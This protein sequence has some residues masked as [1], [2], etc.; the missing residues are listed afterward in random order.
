MR[1]TRILKRRFVKVPAF[2]M[3]DVAILVKVR[4]D[5]IAAGWAAHTR[6]KIIFR[7]GLDPLARSS[8]VQSPDKQKALPA[9]DL[10][11]VMVTR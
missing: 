11:I 3:V 6:T 1:K 10:S 4:L 8:E 2:F 7:T 9:S 5:L